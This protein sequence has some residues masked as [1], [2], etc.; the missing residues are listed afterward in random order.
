MIKSSQLQR[1][2]EVD[3]SDS[4]IAA[5]LGR[6]LAAASLPLT[7]GTAGSA[8]AG[9]TLLWPPAG[10]QFAERNLGGLVLGFDLGGARLFAPGDL[11][12]YPL[13]ELSLRRPPPADLLILPHHGNADPALGALLDQL[14]PRFAIASR[15]D[16]LPA[17]TAAALR[18]R[19]IPWL[20][21]A[22]GG[23]IVFADLDLPG[24]GGTIRRGAAAAEKSGC[25][26]GAAGR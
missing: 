15:D 22:R 17:A 6:A 13:T 1:I 19:K 10:R 18:V 8:L 9:A 23:A 5:A 3:R 25:F 26:L 20:S 12:G 21:T 14:R 4:P 2:A 7:R 11:Q 24:G 16:P